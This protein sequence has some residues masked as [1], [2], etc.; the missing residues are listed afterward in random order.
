MKKVFTSLTLA[1]AAE[2]WLLVG[3]LTFRPVALPP[4]SAVMLIHPEPPPSR[5]TTG[6]AEPD[7]RS[8]DQ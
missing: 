1:W 4:R 3:L 2:V 7:E 6:V 5:L 8:A